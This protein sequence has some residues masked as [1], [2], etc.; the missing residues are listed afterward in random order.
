MH[1]TIAFNYS[2]SSDNHIIYQNHTNMIDTLYAI[3]LLNLYFII[4]FLAS[5]LI[6]TLFIRGYKSRKKWYSRTKKIK[7]PD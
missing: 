7:V 5:L 2:S 6:A 3:G 1:G 4:P